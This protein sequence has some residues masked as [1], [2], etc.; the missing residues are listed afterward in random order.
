MG[1]IADRY[2][3]SWREFMV[4]GGRFGHLKVAIG[5]LAGITVLLWAVYLVLTLIQ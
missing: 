2:R 4:T 5:I 3:E 1:R